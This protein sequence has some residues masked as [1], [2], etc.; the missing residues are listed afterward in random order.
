[1]KNGVGLLQPKIKD[2]KGGGKT[3]ADAMYRHLWQLPLSYELQKVKELRWG[4][5][6]L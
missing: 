4:K 1:M 6:G 2:P 5:H 3:P